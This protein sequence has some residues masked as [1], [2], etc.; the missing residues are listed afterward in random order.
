MLVRA[1]YCYITFRSNITKI[2]T[3]NSY[4]FNI[5]GT[6]FF[7]G[8]SPKINCKVTCFHR[9]A[10]VFV[11]AVNFFVF[12]NKLF[13]CACIKSFKIIPGYIVAFKKFRTNFVNFIF[14]N[15]KT[16]NWKILSIKTRIMKLN[17]ERYV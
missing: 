13:V 3:C 12:L 15:G 14:S 5:K 7:A 2:F 16:H 9:V 6:G 17:K 4:C 11:A 10:Y 1:F 8:S